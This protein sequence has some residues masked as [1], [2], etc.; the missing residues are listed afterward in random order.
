MNSILYILFFINFLFSEYKITAVD[1]SADD[2]FG[3]SVYIDDQWL[4]ISANR[5]YENDINSGSV[6]IY[7]LHE[8]N[9]VQFNTKIYPSDQS[10]NQFFGKAISYHNGWLAISAIYDEDKL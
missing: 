7:Q 3:Q 6:Y 4:F 1:G 9:I 2:R 10:Y 5:D 8:N